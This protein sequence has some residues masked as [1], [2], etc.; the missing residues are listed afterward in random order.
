MTKIISYNVNG[1][2]A[3][4]KKDWVD[5]L[6]SVNP[7]IAC[8]Q[9]TKAS[10][11]Q[12]DIHLFEELGYNTFW[13]SAEKKGY[14]SVAIFTKHEPDHVEYGCG[15]EKYD[16][17]G[18]ILRADYGDFSV[19]SCYFPSGTTGDE[20]QAFKMEFLD[21]FYVYINELKKQRPNLLISGDVNICHEA[22]DIHNPKTNKDTSGFK[23]EEREWVTKFLDAGFVDTF[24]YLNK[25]PHN[26]TWW[27][28]RAGS[29]GKN[30]GWR[31]DY[32]FI[33]DNL[34]NKLKRSVILSEAVHSDHCPIMVELDLN[35]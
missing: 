12:V 33:T 4:M 30:L 2:R 25:E 9:E 22:I 34:V 28:Y 17:E 32:H 31:I 11:D 13:H 7:D 16:K 14:S 35:L 18:R 15:I 29:R 27:S 8:L 24:R 26:Y 19:L 20:R 6:A 10:K 3:A 21:D 5:W 1:I 23:P